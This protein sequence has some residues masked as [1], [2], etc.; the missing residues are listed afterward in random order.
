MG[1]NKTIIKSLK[2]K[3]YMAI[4][5]S[6][7]YKTLLVD[8]CRRIS[9]KAKIAPNEA[10]IESY[11]DCELFTFFRDVFEPLGFEY[12]PT[13][14]AA[15]STRRHI[16]KGRADT[17]IGALVVEFKHV[18]TLSNGEQKNNAIKQ[19]SDYLLGLDYDGETIGFVTDGIKGC[20]VIKNGEGITAESYLPLSP[21]H[22]DR[23]IQSIIGLKLTALNSKNIV[24]NFCNPPEN[25]G[26]AFELVKELYSNLS[27]SSTQKTQ[28]L[29]NE[30]KELFNLAH[31]DISKQQAIIDRKVSLE[32]L[33][34]M[35]L[36][37]K[38]KE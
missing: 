3:Q 28:M 11:F 21:D 24:D 17:A 31:D 1:D 22:L 33:I 19:V 9:Q 20:F 18:L 32:K 13:K 37:E 27:N 2:Q 36:K 8:M 6:Q 16:T 29:F 26:I 30:W 12:N 7:E 34:G 14:E 25:N 38:D 23:L 10:T 5:K 4:V 15:I 35:S